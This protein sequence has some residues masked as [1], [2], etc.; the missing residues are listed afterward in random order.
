MGRKNER[1]PPGPGEVNVKEE[2]VWANDPD[3][4][5]EREALGEIPKV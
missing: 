4:T 1:R 2:G 3:P 5:G